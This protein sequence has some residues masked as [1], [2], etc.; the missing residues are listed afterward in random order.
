MSATH[1]VVVSAA[2]AHGVTG[3]DR[4][5]VVVE[6]VLE[7]T[8]ADDVGD[9]VAANARHA[10]EDMNRLALVRSSGH[11]YGLEVGR[12][13]RLVAVMYPCRQGVDCADADSSVR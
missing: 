13:Q 1:N 2:A 11:D 9:V 10:L 7:A 6:R 8:P 12:E 3:L 5:D 4:L